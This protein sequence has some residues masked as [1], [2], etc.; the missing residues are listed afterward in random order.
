MPEQGVTRDY[1]PKLRYTPAIQRYAGMMYF[2]SVLAGLGTLLL[3]CVVTPIAFLIWVSWKTEQDTV[4]FSAR[5]LWNHVGS[6]FFII[7][8]IALFSPGFL[9]TLYFQR[10]RLSGR[11]RL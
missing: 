4:S 10:R 1:M 8:L 11:H 7:A 2:K 9:P 3:G 6:W 5:G